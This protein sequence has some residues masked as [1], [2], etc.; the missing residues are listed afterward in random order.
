MEDVLHI[1]H[2]EPRVGK[3]FRVLM[4]ELGLSQAETLAWLLINARLLNDAN[5]D[6]GTPVAAAPRDA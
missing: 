2:V 5:A 1:R 3:R 6:G 4:A